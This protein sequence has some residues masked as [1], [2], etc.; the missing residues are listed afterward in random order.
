MLLAGNDEQYNKPSFDA[1][2]APER[3]LAFVKK[4]TDIIHNNIANTSFSVKILSSELDMSRMHLHRKLM[5]IS[6]KTASTLI[7]EI[8]MK[9]A[10]EL[11]STRTMR[12]SEVMRAVGVSNYNLFNK[13]FKDLYGNTPKKFMM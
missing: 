13:Y 8:K 4:V 6:G 5:T 2:I 10:A 3:D 12:V 7:R 11:L 9:K 1:S